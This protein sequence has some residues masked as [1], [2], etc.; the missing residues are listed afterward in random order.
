MGPAEGDHYRNQNRNP[1][2]DGFRS[3]PSESGG[4][5]GEFVGGGEDFGQRAGAAE[6]EEAYEF[7]GQGEAVVEGKQGMGVSTAGSGGRRSW[8]SRL[9]AAGSGGLNWA[10]GEG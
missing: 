9:A 7:V 2:L 10:V 8:G 3:S 5:G 4:E 6:D 1:L